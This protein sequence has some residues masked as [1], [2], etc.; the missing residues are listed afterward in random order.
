MNNVDHGNYFVRVRS[1]VDGSWR[2]VAPD[3]KMVTKRFLIFERQVRVDEQISREKAIDIA[4]KYV[5]ME[6]VQDVE[7]DAELINREGYFMF[8]PST[9]WKNGKWV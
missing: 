4:S 6:G 1:S 2:R 9:I 7:V 5:N 8:H 3:H